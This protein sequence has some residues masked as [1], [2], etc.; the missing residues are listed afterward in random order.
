MQLQRPAPVTDCAWAVPYPCYAFVYR[1]ITLPFW[2]I[3]TNSSTNPAQDLLEFEFDYRYMMRGLIIDKR[4]GNILKMDRHKYV[5]LAFHGFQPLSRDQRLATYANSQVP[6]ASWEPPWNPPCCRPGSCAA[7]GALL[8]FPCRRC[9][10]CEAEDLADA[11]LSLG[12]QGCVRL[13]RCTVNKRM[14]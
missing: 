8:I 2:S 1:E 13:S 9:P 3:F 14:G 7:R 12:M 4:R 5:K 10:R 6:G 11:R